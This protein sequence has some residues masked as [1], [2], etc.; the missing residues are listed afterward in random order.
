MLLVSIED[1]LDFIIASQEYAGSVVD[2]LRHNLQHPTHL[3]VDRL[4]SG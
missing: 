2:M 3:A 4:T 1:L